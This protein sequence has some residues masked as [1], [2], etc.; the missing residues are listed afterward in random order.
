MFKNAA[1]LIKAGI[2]LAVVAAVGYLFYVNKE[3]KTQNRELIASSAVLTYALDESKQEFDKLNR[4]ITNIRT[5]YEK[6][7]KDFAKID[8]N[9]AATAKRI[10]DIDFNKTEN[11][12]DEINKIYREAMRCVE[13]ASG[14]ELT[15]EEKEAKDEVSFNSQC[16][17]AWNGN[18]LGGLQPAK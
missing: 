14:S 17:W 1:F 10:D 16:P 6:A 11:I 5:A 8:T 9:A 3:L 13:L 12:S 4:E 18:A 7:V 15:T 2:A